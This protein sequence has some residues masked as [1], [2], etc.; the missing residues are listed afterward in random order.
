MPDEIA[1]LVY[2]IVWT[3]EGDDDNGVE[4]DTAV[5]YD[6]WP[7][8]VADIKA[9]LDHDRVVLVERSL[10]T[11]AE[12]DEGGEASPDFIRRL[13][14]EAASTNAVDPSAASNTGTPT[15]PRCRVIV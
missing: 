14:G 2:Y 13:R 8:A 7:E 6:E 4:Y 5:V 3:G 11:R 15:P 10:M 12:Y 1:K 9:A